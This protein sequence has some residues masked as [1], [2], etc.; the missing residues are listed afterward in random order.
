MW[1][2]TL[3]D[4][5]AKLPDEQLT[6]DA[7]QQASSAACELFRQAAEAY[8]QVRDADGSNRVDAL[9]NAGNTLTAWAQQAQQQALQLCEQAV[10]AYQAAITKEEDALVSSCC[11][12]RR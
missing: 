11:L 6:L 10:Q 1:A 8:Q 3:L 7:E 12:L 4:I 2:D 9:V 5:A